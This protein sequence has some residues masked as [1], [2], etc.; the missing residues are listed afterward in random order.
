MVITVVI[1]VAAVATV[2]GSNMDVFVTAKPLAS[3]VTT[4][5][6]V[7]TAAVRRKNKSH[8]IDSVANM[9]A[10][11]RTVLRKCFKVNKTV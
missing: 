8:T 5:D 10:N 1:G 11:E 2:A 9:F 7:T 6:V 3:V 4:N